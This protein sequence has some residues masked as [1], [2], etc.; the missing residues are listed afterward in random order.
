MMTK[1]L[2]RG[3]T[4]PLNC[5]FDSLGLVVHDSSR[6]REATRE[7]RALLPVASSKRTQLPRKL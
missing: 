5:P 7:K 1:T 2:V 3:H 6:G 4:E